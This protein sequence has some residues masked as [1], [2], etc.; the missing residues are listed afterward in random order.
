[1]FEGTPTL[2]EIL[3]EYFGCKKPFLKKPRLSA[4]WSDGEKKYEYLTKAGAEAYGKLIG[5]LYDIEKMDVGINEEAIET[6]VE[7]LDAIVCG[8]PY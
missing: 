1:M 4:V 7:T 6:A 2:E 5:L 3:T 8:E